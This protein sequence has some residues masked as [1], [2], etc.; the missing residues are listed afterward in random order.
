MVGTFT[1][2]PI[3]A[4]AVFTSGEA[5]EEFMAE[6]PFLL[7]GVVGERKVREWDEILAPSERSAGAAA[8][9]PYPE[10]SVEACAEQGGRV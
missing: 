3:G 5:A 7:H 1:D 10:P 8:L 2:L 6:D 4:M 9:R